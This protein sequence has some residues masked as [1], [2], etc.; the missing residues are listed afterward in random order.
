MRRIREQHK[1][2]ARRILVDKED[3]ELPDD[4]RE[5]KNYIWNKLENRFWGKKM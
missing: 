2:L 4:F 1:E 5:K 3:I